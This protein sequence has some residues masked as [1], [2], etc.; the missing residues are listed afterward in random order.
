[1]GIHGA[2]LTA[3]HFLTNALHVWESMV[4]RIGKEIANLPMICCCDPRFGLRTLATVLLGNRLP[5]CLSCSLLLCCF[6][7]FL[8]EVISLA[9]LN[10]IKVNPQSGSVRTDI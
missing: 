2:T 10:R 3:A 7:I 6:A 8:L 1:M 9:I 4:L 5:L